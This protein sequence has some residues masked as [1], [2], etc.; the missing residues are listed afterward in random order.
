MLVVGFISYGGEI[1]DTLNKNKSVN[2]LGGLISIIDPNSS[3]I[4]EKAKT[5]RE[6]K[7]KFNLIINKEE[8][9]SNLATLQNKSQPVDILKSIIKKIYREN[10]IKN[11]DIKKVRE[12]DQELEGETKS[13]LNDFLDQIKNL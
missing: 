11:L 5:L 8:E 13:N 3:N 10:M 1:H 12:L 4:E 6:I 2:T 9:R 7:N